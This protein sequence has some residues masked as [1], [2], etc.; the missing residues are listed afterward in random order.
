MGLIHCN[1][2]VLMAQRGLNIQKVKDQTTLSRTTIS[3]LYNNLGSGIQFG[4]LIELCELLNCKPGDLLSY[5][6][7]E[8]DFKVDAER[9]YSVREDTLVDEKGNEREYVSEIQIDLNMNTSL[10]YEGKKDNLEFEVYV[11]YHL[12]EKK[13]MSSIVV[14]SSA[15]LDKSLDNLVIPHAKEY[16][17]EELSDYLINWGHDRFYGN[18]IEGISNLSVNHGFLIEEKGK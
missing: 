1:L 12:D 2:R 4:T 5:I 10:L 9:G 11:E 17:L 15:D 13:E 18:E 14:A 16:F 3:N 7:M 8:M 6:Q